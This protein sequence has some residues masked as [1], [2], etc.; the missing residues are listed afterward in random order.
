MRYR[1]IQAEKAHYPVGV[2]CQI[3]AVARSGFYAWCRRPMS[4]R[5]HA[6]T[7][8]FAYLE[9]FYNRVRR[10]STLGYVSPVEFEQRAAYSNSG[11]H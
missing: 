3:L 11:F 6:R 1:F 5:A 7:E 4:A 8:I 2:L 9:G 10:H